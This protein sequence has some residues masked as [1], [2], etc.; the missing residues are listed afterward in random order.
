MDSTRW[1]MES[2]RVS[3]SGSLVSQVNYFQVVKILYFFMTAFTVSATRSDSVLTR[4]NDCLCRLQWNAKAE[5]CV[6]GC[7]DPYHHPSWEIQSQVDSS[8]SQLVIRS[9]FPALYANKHRKDKRTQT[10]EEL[11]AELRRTINVRCCQRESL[12]TLIKFLLIQQLT[13]LSVFFKA[14][15]WQMQ[16]VLF[17]MLT[18]QEGRKYAQS[19]SSFNKSQNWMIC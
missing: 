16:I 5:M 2:E 6:R 19:F 1:R 18:L 15:W 13:K 7:S 14:V 9:H 3:E 11:H 12:I 10:Q 17:L 4:L 8:T